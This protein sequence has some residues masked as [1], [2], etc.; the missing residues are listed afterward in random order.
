MSCIVVDINECSSNPC[1]NLATCN[2]L[3]DYY[4]CSCA[5]GW[6]GE[7]CDTGKGNLKQICYT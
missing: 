6:T 1:L 3:V 4:N 5:D 7:I 2:N